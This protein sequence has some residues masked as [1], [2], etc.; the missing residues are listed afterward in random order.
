[1]RKLLYLLIVATLLVLIRNTSVSI[2]HLKQDEATLT[3]LKKQLE[4]EKKLNSFYK[5]RLIYVKKTEYIEE[6]ARNKLNLTRPGEFIVV[7]SEIEK[8]KIG[9]N[10]FNYNKSNWKKWYELF[11]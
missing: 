6:E 8:T 11:F 9:S 4:E 2:L 3:N 1:M 5:E 7:G 10:Q